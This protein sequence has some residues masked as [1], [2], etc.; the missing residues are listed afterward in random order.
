MSVAALDA[1][2]FTL[3]EWAHIIADPTKDDRHLQ[4]ALGPTIAD[5]LRW[6]R[7]EDG[8]AARTI[9]SYERI[10]AQLAIVT[11][12]GI[13]ELTIDHLR[14]VRDMRPEGSRHMV[15][16]VY[17]DFCK[18]L[19]QE[20][21]TAVDI[22][23]RLRYPRRHAAPLTGLFTDEE[24]AAIV[25]AQDT[26]RDRVGVLLLL[27]AGIRKGELRHMRVRDLDLRECLILVRRGKGGKSRRIPIRGSLVQALDEYLLT[28]IPGLDRFP[29]PDDYI[30]YPLSARRPH[31][32]N[33]GRPMADSTAHYWWYRCLARAEIVEPDANSGRHMHTTRHT[34]AT[35]LGRATGW[36]FLAVQKNLGHSKFA[37]TVD[38]YTQ[39]AFEDQEAAVDMLPEIETP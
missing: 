4:T 37:T 1:R 2:R 16:A 27:R 38:T 32:P 25:A 5:Y 19:Y 23:G 22:A 7:N 15:T 34:Y 29:E 35:D 12:V 39:F 36:N 24:K 18:W 14:T 13:D 6:K 30:L 10:L 26:I 8:A 20:A 3:D 28:V 17:K 21:R 33:P 31:H 9:D 11:R